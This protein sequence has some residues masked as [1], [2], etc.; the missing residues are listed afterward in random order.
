MT[1]GRRLPPE[2]PPPFVHIDK[3]ARGRPAKWIPD[4]VVRV[5]AKDEAIAELVVD[6]LT[7][8][9]TSHPERVHVLFEIDARELGEDER[10]KLGEQARLIPVRR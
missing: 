3:P 10:A 5:Q 4:A 9:L 7:D 6:I 2:R 1:R 8:A